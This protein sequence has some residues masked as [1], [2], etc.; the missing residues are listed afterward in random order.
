MV[1]IYLKVSTVFLMSIVMFMFHVSPEGCGQSR[2]WLLS[3]FSISIKSTRPLLIFGL[4]PIRT[5]L[6]SSDMISLLWLRSSHIVQLVMHTSN[7][8]TQRAELERLQ[9][10]HYYFHVDVA[11]A[12]AGI[13]RSVSC[14]QLQT[15]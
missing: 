1:G 9:R 11:V 7:K 10:N 13:A 12:V 5:I 15:I 3:A 6:P 2:S 8:L 4:L 14:L